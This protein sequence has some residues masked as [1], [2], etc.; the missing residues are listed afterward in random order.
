MKFNK[1]TAVWII[2]FYALFASSCLEDGD[3]TLVL[4]DVENQPGT[5]TVTATSGSYTQVSRNGFL[6]TVPIQSISETTSGNEGRL[7]FSME[8]TE[9]LPR[10]LPSH[11]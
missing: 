9:D 8:V 3:K 7:V 4:P 6:L 10:S 1:L 11:L 5:N 2:V